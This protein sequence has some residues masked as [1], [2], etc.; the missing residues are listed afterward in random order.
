MNVD[1]MDVAISRA[2]WTPPAALGAPFP[3]G[4]ASRTHFTPVGVPVCFSGAESVLGHKQ[5]M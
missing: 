4:G 2:L 1:V 5:Y 3:G